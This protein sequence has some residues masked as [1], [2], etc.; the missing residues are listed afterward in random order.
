MKRCDLP[1]AL[2]ESKFEAGIEI[3][4]SGVVGVHFR[5]KEAHRHVDKAGEPLEWGKFQVGGQF[6][7]IDTRL[8]VRQTD[9]SEELF[10]VNR[11]DELAADCATACGG[12][13]V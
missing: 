6:L 9:E 3:G 1:L 4:E 5:I 8:R 12:A 10:V 13:G 7:K 11:P 2:E